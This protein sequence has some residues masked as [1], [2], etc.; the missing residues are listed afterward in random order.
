MTDVMR[1]RLLEAAWSLLSEAKG[2]IAAVKMQAV[3]DRARVTSG[4]FY[5][6]W[7]DLNAFQSDLLRYGF[8]QARAVHSDKIRSSII[9]DLIGPHGPAE[10]LD[11]LIMRYARE[12]REALEKDPSFGLWVALWARRSTLSGASE[13]IKDGY[14]EIDGRWADLYTH[15]L[16]AYGLK[17]RNPFTE[18][19]LSV[20]LTAILEGLVLRGAVDAEVV[21][22]S[23][24]GSAGQW[25]LFGTMVAALLPVITASASDAEDATVWEV[26]RQ[27]LTA[28][29]QS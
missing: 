27:G 14:A 1:E 28:Y 4:A 25:E 8:S 22:L 11:Q 2:D 26:A 16:R 10:P 9:S 12:D 3:V 5:S 23:H 18:R 19:D 21:E 15:I 17:V 7:D 24:V 29:T 13:V 6:N 20:M